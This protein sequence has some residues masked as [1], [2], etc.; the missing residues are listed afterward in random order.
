[1]S[2][3]RLSLSSNLFPTTTIALE[4]SNLIYV[5]LKL[6]ANLMGLKVLWKSGEF[7]NPSSFPYTYSKKVPGPYGVFYISNRAFYPVI[8]SLS[9]ETQPYF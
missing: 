3:P 9:L 4:K 1:M 7:W 8:K 6:W 2:G 5:V